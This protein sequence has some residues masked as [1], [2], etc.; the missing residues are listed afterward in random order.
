LA[1]D[2]AD[3]AR[4]AALDTAYEAFLPVNGEFKR[5]CTDWQ[6]RSDTGEPNDHTDRAYDDGVVARLGEVHDRITVV[7]KDL[8]AA[9]GRFDAYIRR[10]EN[11][12]ERIG[13]GDVAACA[14]PLA[15]SYHDIWVA[16]H[17]D[18]LL[19]L[20]KERAAKAERL[21]SATAPETLPV[22]RRRAGRPALPSEAGRRFPP[23]PR[24][25][26]HSL[27]GTISAA[28]PQ[29]PRDP[30]PLERNGPRAG[31][32]P[33][34]GGRCGRVTPPCGLRAWDRRGSRA[35]RS[36]PPPARARRRSSA[37][38][39]RR[40]RTP[41]APR[42]RTARDW[43]TPPCPRGS[44][45]LPPRLYCDLQVILFPSIEA[46]QADRNPRCTAET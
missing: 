7:L 27:S 2:V 40:G 41:R 43:R 16:L 35:P 13:G 25:A 19:S 10:L 14:R 30:V 38:R 17:Q 24:S 8:A 26:R 22:L 36:R 37:R 29:R 6:V 32:S 45:W 33:L 18:L 1:A 9:L 39:R 44:S 12:L 31:S 46:G 34:R 11:A 4:K 20:Q 23:R 3:P 42:T 5:L 28:P 15:D 21:R